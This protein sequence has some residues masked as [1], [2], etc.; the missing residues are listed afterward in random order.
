MKLTYVQRQDAGYFMELLLRLRDGKST[1]EDWEYIM[2]HC[3]DKNMT[4]EKIESFQDQDT[5]WL[6]NTNDENNDHNI[7]QLNSL[8]EPICLINAEHDKPVSK[9]RS[10]KGARNL[11][12]KLYLSK[13]SKVMLLWNINITLGLVNGSIGYVIG[14]IYNEGKKAPLL[15]YSIII[16]FDDYSGVPFFSGVGQEKWVPVLA[17]E[18]KWGE[19]HMPTHFRK[20]FPLSLSWALT[21]WKSQGLT[22]KGLLAYFLG[23]EE[24]EH[25]LTYVAFS[26]ILAIE[27]MYVGQGFSLDRL[28]TDIS[29][30]FKLKKRLEEDD[31]LQMLYE[32]TK[33]FYNLL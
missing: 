14:F 4:R 20:Q 15:P 30:G 3:S 29:K 22:I 18:Y 10:S 23:K 13:K 8:N 17:S 5:I 25:G 11:S 21:V 7:K 2:L 28:T 33:L 32:E 16:S 1:K 6:F 27:Q 19:E 12:S 31:R 24:K 26:R 9:G